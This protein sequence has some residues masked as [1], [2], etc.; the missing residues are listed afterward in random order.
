MR[1]ASLDP[2]QAT[3]LLE[4]I[5]DGDDSAAE[6]LAPLLYDELRDVAA[7]CMARQ[8]DSHTLQPTALVHEAWLRIVT[9]AGDQR[10][11][12]RTHFV[13]AA[14]RTMRHVLV[15]HARARSARKRD[16]GRSDLPLDAVLAD[17]ERRSID[18]L[19]L[20]DA[21]ERLGEIDEQLARIVELR[22]FAG[23]TVEEAAEVLGISVRTVHRGWSVARLW[24]QDALS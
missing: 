20:S 15:D 24:L 7:A 1:S 6:E 3:R 12:N 21:L 11:S 18:V 4:R 19:A 22:F 5:S 10:Y 23:R 8:R 13:R 2:G 16:A 17:F 9:G 14:A